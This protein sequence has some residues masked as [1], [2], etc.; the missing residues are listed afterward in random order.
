MQDALLIGF[1]A[2]PYLTSPGLYA[3]RDFT[4]SSMCIPSSPNPF[5]L[6][7]SITCKDGDVMRRGMGE[8]GVSCDM[9]LISCVGGVCFRRSLP[10]SGHQRT[11]DFR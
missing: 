5:V 10:H 9:E 1:K 2:G 4:A 6:K 7:N 8:V 3:L 11:P